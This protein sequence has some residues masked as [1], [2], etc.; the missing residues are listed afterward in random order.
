MAKH[1]FKGTSIPSFAPKQ[2]G[3]HY[4][5]TVSKIS[6][7][8]VGTSDPSDWKAEASNITSVNGETGPTIVLDAGDIGSTPTGD[9]SATN[10]QSAIAELAS[11][12]QALSEKGQ[13]NGYASLD[14]SGKVPAAQ[15][16]SY[17]DDVLEYANLGAFP[18]TG[19]TSKIYVALDT[20]KTYRWTGSV[21][22]E[23][24][25]SEVNSVFGRTGIVTAQ[26]GDYNASQITNTPAGTISSTNVQTALNEL[27][28]EKVPT[29]R[30]ISAGTGLSGGGDLS[31]NRTI[32]MP[33]VGTAGSYG[34]ATQIPVITTDAQGRVSA[35]TPT[36]L[37]LTAQEVSATGSTSTTSG[38]DVLMNNMTI[39]PAAGTYMVWFSTTLQSNSSDSNIYISIYAAGT[40]K[41]DSQRQAQPRVDASGGLGGDGTLDINMIAATNGIVTV[42]GSQAIEIRWRRDSGTATA[43]QRTLNILKL[44]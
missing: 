26:S 30:T 8:S 36:A 18:G 16:P 11:E 23:I 6:Y 7:I 35:V 37:N 3:H 13:I 34:S 43:L 24:S 12:K 1:I 5:D 44:S 19:E 40:Q 22:V 25:P 4:V 15:L 28:T 2:I 38:S 39:T 33:N 14:G 42:N 17:V 21:Y 32:S 10:V 9:V 20:N 27:D 41:A 29:T 31:T